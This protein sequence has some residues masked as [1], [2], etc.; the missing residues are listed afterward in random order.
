MFLIFNNFSNLNYLEIQ[1]VSVLY[2]ILVPLMIY[3]NSDTD[4][5]K[6]L[7]ENKGKTG[8]YLW[9]HKESGK[10]Y[11]G[12]AVDLSKRM[13]NYFSI[14]YLDRKK[15][16]YICRALKNHGYST[17]SLTIY[18]HINISGL[19]KE[20][21]RKLILEREQFY[22]DILSPNYNI[23]KKAGSW[24]GFNHS[25]GTKLKLSE[26]NKGENHPMFGRNHSPETLALISKNHARPWLGKSVSAE[27][28]DKISKSLYKKVF[29]YSNS[30]SILVYEFGSHLEAAKHFNCSSMTISRYVK[31]D[32][33]FKKQWILSASIIIKE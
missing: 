21:A 11:V 3:P 24:L 14:G 22:L 20:E 13:Y 9:E 12:S 28:K 16:M 10:K 30:S 7:A 33:I 32:Y 23:L 6:I 19:S 31:N 15:N 29:V 17:F 5:S 8:I 27:T 26:M 25:E 2:S 18:E 4:K 1:E